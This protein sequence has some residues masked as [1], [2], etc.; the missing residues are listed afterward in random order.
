MQKLYSAITTFLLSFLLF[1]GGLQAQV[2]NNAL[3]TVNSSRNWSV[4]NPGI[5][6]CNNCSVTIT[7]TAV[8]TI[9]VPVTFSGSVIN[10]TNSSGLSINANTSLNT[11][12]VIIGDASV[13]TSS[14][15]TGTASLFIANN[16]TLTL[17]DNINRIR[18]ANLN[19]TITAGAG[20]S[21]TT[22]GQILYS[23]TGS[24][25]ALFFS[26]NN[27][28]NLLNGHFP[29]ANSPYSGPPAKVT[30]PAISG[31]STSFGFT[32][33]S[34]Q[35]SLV[36]LPISLVDF[37]ASLNASGYVD[38]AWA[39]DE[40]VNSDHFNVQRDAN[41]TGWKTIGEV[42]AQG[43]SKLK[44]QYA[45]R[46]LN[47]I[48]GTNSYRL[49]PVDKNGTYTFSD[50]KVIRTILSAGYNVFPN[51][52]KENLF[53]SLGATADATIRLVDI[54]GKVLLEKKVSNAANTTVALPVRSFMQGNYILQVKTSGGDQFTKMVLITRQ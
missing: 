34:F 8:L 29:G 47:P 46:D 5:S 7:G 10:V 4:I 50:I 18:L 26:G 2:L 1:E 6:V 22:A 31:T 12:E 24:N 17:L 21:G 28:V 40:E 51:P 13:S 25:T 16:A 20:G 35:V 15:A 3:I 36:I 41:G 49:Q 23:A 39:T 53:V 38:L 11:T 52:A 37:T 43:N 48:T 9:D 44:T 42:K 45:F 30:G 32:T 14:L 54:S 19:N 33:A 27:N